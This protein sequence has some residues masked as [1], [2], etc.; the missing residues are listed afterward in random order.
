MALPIFVDEAAAMAIAFRLAH[1]EPP[2][3]LAQDLL[4]D[5]VE[6]LGGQVTEVRIDD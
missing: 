3:P 1:V 2:H 6:E 5:V 4:D